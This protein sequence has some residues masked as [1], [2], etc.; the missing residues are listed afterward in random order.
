MSLPAALV[1]THCHLTDRRF[2]DDLPAVLDRAAAAGVRCCLTIATGL[3]DA[4]RAAELCRSHPQVAMAAGL[5]PFSC[6]ASDDPEADLARLEA[7]ARAG[8]L[9]AIGEFGLEFHHEVLPRERQESLALAQLRL[10][11]SLAL[12]V[13]LHARSGRGIHAHAAMLALLDQ[14]EGV[15]GVIHSFDGDGDDAEGYVRRGFHVA[16]NGMVSFPANAGLRAALARI[17]DDRLLLETDAPYLSPVPLRGRR[18]E[19]AH[20]VHTLAAVAAALGRD[21]AAVAAAS[22]ANAR[23]LFWT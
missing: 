8:G 22:S 1:D 11:R 13:V 15:R 10:A 6:H 18:N 20:L 3:A 21:P 5:D 17:P 19:P 7:L 23:A 16:V 12:P 2:A 14:A 4:A 9:R